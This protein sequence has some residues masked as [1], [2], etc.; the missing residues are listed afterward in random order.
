MMW[1]R[2]QRLAGAMV[3]SAAVA[4]APAPAYDPAGTPADWPPPMAPPGPFWQVLVD[5]LEASHGDGDT[6]WAW[7]TQG[8]YGGDYERLRFKSEGDAEAGAAPDEAELQVLYSR[9]F[10]PFWDW[11]LGVRQRFNP[12]GATAA[13]VGVQGL[14][15]YR[16]EWD[17]ALFIDTDGKVSTRLEAEY[18]LRLTQRLVLQPRLELEAAFSN[19]RAGGMASGL[20]SSALE[21]RLRYQ[22]RREFAPYL[23]VSWTQL[24]GGT[25]R[26]ARG[27]GQGGSTFAAVLGLRMWF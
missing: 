11:Q 25:K 2:T 8:W 23:G 22:V 14:A 12:R 18:N 7:D 24:Y 1:R 26:A 19:D 27:E 20:N 10:L 3:L 13:V 15:P 21:L 9:L 5:R 17:S 6:G 16:F 4:V